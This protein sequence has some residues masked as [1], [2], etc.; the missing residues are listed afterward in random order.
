MEEQTNEAQV[1]LEKEVTSNPAEATNSPQN[2]LFGTITYADDNAYDEFIA[3]MNLNQ[4]L[5]VL[6]ASANFAQKQGAFNLLESESLA[7]AIRTIRKTGE[8]ND[9]QSQK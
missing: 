6:I 1:T 2:I 3:N 8:K 4:A 7:T 5:F 9:S